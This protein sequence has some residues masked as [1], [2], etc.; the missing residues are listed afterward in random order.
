MTF[1][2]LYKLLG[3]V[4]FLLYMPDKATEIAN[5]TIKNKKDVYWC[6]F[7]IFYFMLAYIFLWPIF[8]IISI[9]ETEK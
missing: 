8:V 6:I 2:A 4:Y 1:L 9:F 7:M 5:T 3:I